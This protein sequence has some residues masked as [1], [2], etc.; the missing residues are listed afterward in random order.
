[1]GRTRK[2]GNGGERIGDGH[3]TTV[4]INVVKYTMKVLILSPLKRK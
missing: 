4:S 3:P 1:M 2:V